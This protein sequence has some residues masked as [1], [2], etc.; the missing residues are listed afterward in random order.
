MS[1]QNKEAVI[2]VAM[3]QD[4]VGEDGNHYVTSTISGVVREVAVDVSDEEIVRDFLAYWRPDPYITQ[5]ALLKVFAG[6]Q[7][8]KLKPEST[9]TQLEMGKPL[10]VK[11]EFCGSNPFTSCVN[12]E[13]DKSMPFFHVQRV[14]DSMRQV[15]AEPTLNAGGFILAGFGPKALNTPAEPTPTQEWHPCSWDMTLPGHAGMV[16]VLDIDSRL[17]C[18]AKDRFTA[19]QIVAAYNSTL[20]GAPVTPAEPTPACK[21]YSDEDGDRIMCEVCADELIGRE[22]AEPIPV[23]AARKGMA[24]PMGDKRLKELTTAD[25]AEIEELNQIASELLWFRKN[26]G[27]S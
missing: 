19:Q 7:R 23:R 14:N 18:H 4:I 6:W 22:A 5:F 26:R 9:P 20:L 8:S 24:A 3:N 11:C 16:E 17:I 27:N 1:D 12:R 21:C 13:T 2:E 10:T 15:A 25:W